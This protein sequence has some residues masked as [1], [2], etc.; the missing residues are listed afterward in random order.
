[1][2]GPLLPGQVFQSAAP[3]APFRK[4]DGDRPRGLLR[5]SMSTAG[6]IQGL[7]QDIHNSGGLIQDIHNSATRLI[8]DIHNSAIPTTSRLLPII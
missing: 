2:A 5:P 6:L 4:S 7:I 1:M 8:Q 3:A